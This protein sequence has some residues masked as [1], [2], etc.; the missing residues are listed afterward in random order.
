[1]AQGL[2]GEVK[3]HAMAMGK[4]FKDFS[5]DEVSDFEGRSPVLEMWEV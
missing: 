3:A 4:P 1:L 5:V 2:I